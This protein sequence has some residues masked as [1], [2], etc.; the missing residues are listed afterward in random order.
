[1]TAIL[2]TEDLGAVVFSSGKVFNALGTDRLST[3]GFLRDGCLDGVTSKADLSLLQDL[4]DVAH[5]V[6]SHTSDPI[7]ADYVVAINTLLS[8]TGAIHPGRLREPD[9]AIGVSTRYGRH[10]PEALALADLQQIIDESARDPDTIEAALRLFVRLAAAQPFE[11]GNKRTALFAANG[12]LINSGTGKLLPVP[13]DDDDP[14]VATTFNDLLAR[15]YVVH[16]ESP[17]KALMRRH[18]IDLPQPDRA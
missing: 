18:V 16:D 6:V 13:S 17:V 12:L 3:E 2:R 9:Q 4:Q 10:P 1:M 14:Q 11:D 5:F 15:A 8:R 7:D